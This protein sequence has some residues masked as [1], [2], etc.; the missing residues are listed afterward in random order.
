[1]EGNYIILD[2]IYPVIFPKAIGHKELAKLLREKEITS[3]GFVNINEHG[4]LM[5]HGESF[6]LKLKPESED[7]LILKASFKRRKTA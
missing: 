1:M 2:G 4:E 7:S 5:P 3:A 6:S